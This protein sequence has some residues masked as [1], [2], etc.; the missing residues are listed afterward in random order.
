MQP[1]FFCT[2]NVASLIARDDETK[3]MIKEKIKS[4]AHYIRTREFPEEIC[5]KIKR[6]FEYSWKQ[7]QVNK[8]IATLFIPTLLITTLQQKLICS[9]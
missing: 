1:P 2:G 5:Q 6:H 8:L 9:Q 3:L 4:V 7:N